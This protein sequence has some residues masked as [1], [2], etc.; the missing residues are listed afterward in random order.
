MNNRNID[1]LPLEY[2]YQLSRKK[3]KL[4]SLDVVTTIRVQTANE[5]HY[6]MPGPGR[7]RRRCC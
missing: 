3:K 6:Y 1:N 7:R 2:F 4:L 5:I